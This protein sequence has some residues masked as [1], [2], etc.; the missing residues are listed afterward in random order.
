[1]DRRFFLK[2]V[3]GLAGAGAATAL[4]APEAQALPL[5]EELQALD[6]AGAN[7]LMAS[8]SDLP[9][10][11]ASEA[12]YYYGPPPGYYRRRPRRYYRPPPRVRRCRTFY[13]RWGRLVRRCWWG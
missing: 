11:G 13:D 3:L 5:L 9:A 2:S 10:Q 1:M 12:Q 8:E 6:A 4:L 7:P